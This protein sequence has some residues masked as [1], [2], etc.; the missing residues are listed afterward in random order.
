MLVNHLLEESA[1][2]H[3]DKNAVWFNNTWKSYGQIDLLSNQVGNYLKERGLKRGDRIALLYENSFEYVACYFGILKAGCVAVALNTDVN[4][5]SLI[6]LLNNSDSKAI[7]AGEKFTRFLLPA[8]PK[9]PYLTEVIIDQDDLTAYREIG[10]LNPMSLK[11]IWAKCSEKH[12]N[13]RTISIDLSAIV[14]TSGSTGEPKG[15]MLSHM[16]F[17][18]NMH[19]I[20]SYLHLTEKDSMMVVL[21][22]FYIYGKSLLLTHFLVGGAVVIDN[23]FAY[24]NVVLE[25]M[26]QMEVTGFAGV[27]STF[28]ILLNRSSLRDLQFPKL[29]YVTQAG[30]AMAPAVQKE[31]VKVF[32]PAELYVMYGATEAAP[33]LSYLEPNMLEKKWGSIGKAIPDV[34]LFVA[35]EHGK[36]LPQGETGEIAARGANI[37]Q[38]YW[39]DKEATEQVLR[40][41][42]YYTGDLG[43]LDEE[44]Y[45]FVVGRSKDII[46][47]KGYR[48]SAKE[49]E[50][51]ILE[52]NT[53]HEVAAIGVD[54][55]VLGEAVKVFVVPREGV[56]LNT[57]EIMQYCKINLPV[58]KQPKYIEV[59][60]A[61]PK[62][63]A[64]KIMKTILKENQAINNPNK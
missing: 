5:E 62:N 8:L 34:D 52:I 43:K 27:P 9:V 46:K 31:V 49:I 26:K 51:K 25:S 29:R 33:R 19:S 11:E 37:F 35:D 61:L 32:A 24:P 56:V 63:K 18:S 2:K 23:R 42:L 44:G 60:E 57:N 48:V 20:A 3:P 40:N 64:G 47:V 58:Y 4:S 22:F 50:E 54:D 15:V 1:Q 6:Y 45:L 16:N 30:G 59:I 7:L 12:P 28:M 53:I 36:E 39:K 55:P 38:G 10:H 13:V 17:V 21:P 41:G 14:Y